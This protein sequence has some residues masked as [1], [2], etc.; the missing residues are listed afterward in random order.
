MPGPFSPPSRAMRLPFESTILR[1]GPEIRHLAV[2]RHAGAEFADNKIR[3]LGPAATAQR[4]GPVQIIPLRLVFAV[5]VEHLHAVVLAVGDI[6]PAVG[7][8]DD[9]V[10]D[11]ELAG[12]GARLAPG[13]HQFSIG[14]VFVDAG[15]A[16]AVRHVDLALRRQRGMGAAMERLAAHERRRLVRDADGQQHLAVGGA[17]AHGMVAVIGAIEIVVGVDVQPVGAVEQPFAPACDEIAVAIQHHHRMRAAIE[18]IDAV[19]GVDR[20]GSDIGEIPP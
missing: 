14:A 19:L 8:G 7:V 2:D 12:I 9:I 15:I 1:R 11:V 10:H 5:A 6:D 13:L 20:D 18:Q 16:V 4:A 17:L 3:I